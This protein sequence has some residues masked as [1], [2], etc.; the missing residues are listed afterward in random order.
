MNTLIRIIAQIVAPIIEAL[1]A[2]ILAH[3]FRRAGTDRT[4]VAN[5]EVVAAALVVAVILAAFASMF[6]TLPASSSSQAHGFP[7]G[8]LLAGVACVA[9]L[10][11]GLCTWAAVFG[12]NIVLVRPLA[13]RRYHYD[14]VAGWTI[15]RRADTGRNGP[16]LLAI[17]MK[18]GQRFITTI[19]PTTVP[20]VAAR[21]EQNV[22]AQPAAS[23]QPQPT[24]IIRR[25]R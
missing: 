23:P 13:I 15:A 16:L 1:L 24:R 2:R 25:H 7:F 6:W 8:L 3:L 14:D 4:I 21:L 20:G 5:S 12:E 18:D 17:E 10:C 19:W 11:L 22:P 9:A